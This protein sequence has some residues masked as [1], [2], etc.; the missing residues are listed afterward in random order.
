MLIS[1]VVG[2]LSTI[3]VVKS[4]CSEPILEKIT[5]VNAQLIAPP[6]ILIYSHSPKL[7]QIFSNTKTTIINPS[8]L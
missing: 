2:L 5:R 1:K 7:Q 4:E 3:R 6:N 8:T